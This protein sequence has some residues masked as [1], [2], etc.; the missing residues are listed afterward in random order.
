MNYSSFPLVWANLIISQSP[1]TH[2]FLSYVISPQLDIQLNGILLPHGQYVGVVPP[3][4]AIFQSLAWSRLLK[5]F[6]NKSCVLC[7]FNVSSD[8]F[9]TVKATPAPPRKIL[10]CDLELFVRLVVKCHRGNL[11]TQKLQFM[12]YQIKIV[13]HWRQTYWVSLLIS[14]NF[15]RG[16]SSSSRV[17]A[18]N[19][20]RCHS[21]TRT[22]A[23]LEHAQVVPPDGKPNFLPLN[24][25]VAALPA[26][27]ACLPIRPRRRPASNLRTRRQLLPANNGQNLPTFLTI[28]AIC[29][30]IWRTN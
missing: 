2:L 16:F 24:L 3:N 21:P 20:T 30:Q 12:S 1:I 5:L 26:Q 6:I 15:N 28:L 9:Q 29:W 22:Q 17:P 7:K 11:V 25:H 13:K 27:L 19:R 8:K 23:Q 4:P 18:R 10:M 14:R